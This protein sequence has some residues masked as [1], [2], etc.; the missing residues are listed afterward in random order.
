MSADGTNR[1]TLAPSIDIEGASGQGA[2]E[3]SPDGT[4]IVAGGR[5][6]QGPALFLISADG[7]GAPVRLV[8]GNW[9]NP[10]WSPD[11]NVIVYAGQ[12]IVGTVDLLG[13]RPDGTSIDLPRV[14]ARPG[15]YRFLPNGSGIVYLPRI[16]GLDF[17]LFDFATK[18]SRP[19]TG[20]SNEGAL[21]TFDIT[22]DGKYIV[23][24]RSRQNS[25]IV[26][27]DLPK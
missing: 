23:F 20:L 10:I 13:V 25:D 8:E 3:W 11:G 24:D 14:S 22:P 2:A 26:L 5:D 19:L 1:R 17:W 6:Q 27:I 21:R 12:S 15:G 9:V 16:Q 7:N 18:K 4:R